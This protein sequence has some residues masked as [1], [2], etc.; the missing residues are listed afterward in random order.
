MPD[1]SPMTVSQH[2]APML[3]FRRVDSARVVIAGGHAVAEITAV[4]HRYPHTFRVPLAWV[5]RLAASGVS[6]EIEQRDRIPDLADA[7]GSMGAN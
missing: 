4:T 1:A 2:A 6:V 3:G 5:T 7:V